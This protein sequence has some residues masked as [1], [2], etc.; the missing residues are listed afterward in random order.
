MSGG[1]QAPGSA[2]WGRRDLPR[3]AGRSPCQRWGR[4]TTSTPRRSVGREHRNR[5]RATRWERPGNQVHASSD[6]TMPL[7]TPHEP[8]PSATHSRRPCDARFIRP[9]SST[10]CAHQPM[11]TIAA[12]STAPTCPASARLGHCAP[13]VPLMDAGNQIDACSRV[14]RVETARLKVAGSTALGDGP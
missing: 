5:H 11:Q 8:A 13:T 3:T 9:R 2:A 4:T 1:V 12:A 14:A 6:I 10:A 7:N